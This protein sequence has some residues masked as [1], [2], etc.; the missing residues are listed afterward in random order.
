MSLNPISI[1]PIINKTTL[2][3]KGDYYSV[4]WIKDDIASIE[5]DKKVYKNISNS[6][7]FL[8]ARIDWKIK[9][10]TTTSSETINLRFLP[11]KSL[12]FIETL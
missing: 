3:N 7:F 9:K 6:I 5:I 1:A 2:K 12:T 10:K 8:N 11:I 4:C